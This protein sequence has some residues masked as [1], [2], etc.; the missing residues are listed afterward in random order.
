MGRKPKES[1]EPQIEAKRRK[2]R[3][4]QTFHLKGGVSVTISG[5]D[6]CHWIASSDSVSVST[7]GPIL[8]RMGNAFVSV[9]PAPVTET[10]QERPGSDLPPWAG[11]ILKASGYEEQK[12]SRAAT[13]QQE[14]LEEAGL[15]GFL[16]EMEMAARVA[17]LEGGSEVV[18]SGEEQ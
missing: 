15:G 13:R 3:R 11:E 14:L 5:V 4:S 10:P 9:G 1:T 6:D 18:P 7:S 8:Q 16:Q 12:K 17:P 2:R